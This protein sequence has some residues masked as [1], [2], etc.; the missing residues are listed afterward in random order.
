MFYIEE[1]HELWSDVNKTALLLPWLLQTIDVYYIYA[2]YSCQTYYTLHINSMFYVQNMFQGWLSFYIYNYK[3]SV[4]R[5][6]R[7]A[8]AVVSISDIIKVNV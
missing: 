1:Y 5:S 4:T 6:A 2:I 8:V 7:T 3:C